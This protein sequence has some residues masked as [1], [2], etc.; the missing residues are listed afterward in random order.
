MN[1]SDLISAYRNRYSTNHVL[2]RLIE[3]LK[4]TL[5]KNIFIGAVLMK[6]SKAFDCIPHW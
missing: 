6:F 4:T 1:L 5:D 2:I 3:N